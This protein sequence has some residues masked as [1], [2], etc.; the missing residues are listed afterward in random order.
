MKTPEEIKAKIAEVDVDSQALKVDDK[1]PSHMKIQG[2][3][4][5]AAYTNALKWVLT[6]K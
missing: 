4:V 6:E 2:M 1:T 5:R 3:L